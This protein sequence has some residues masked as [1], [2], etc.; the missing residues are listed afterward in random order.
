MTDAGTR[1][2]QAGKQQGG[3]TIVHA[4]QNVRLNQLLAYQSNGDITNNLQ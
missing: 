4:A 3:T 1:Q 2:C